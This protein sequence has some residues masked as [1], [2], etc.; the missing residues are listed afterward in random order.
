MNNTKISLVSYLKKNLDIFSWCTSSLFRG[1]KHSV[2]QEVI[3]VYYM[4]NTKNCIIIAKK[5]PRKNPP[6][7]LKPEALGRYYNLNISKDYTI[8]QKCK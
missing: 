6:V 1:K 2:S 3:H 4:N 5:L 8:Y 7:V